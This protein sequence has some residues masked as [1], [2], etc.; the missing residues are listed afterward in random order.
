LLELLEEELDELELDDDELELLEEL[1]DD[2]LELLPELEELL[3]VWLLPLELDELVPEA[4]CTH[5][6]AEQTRLS[7]LH[8]LPS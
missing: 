2:E 5:T 3:L 7:E 8:G 6:P 4:P 1:D